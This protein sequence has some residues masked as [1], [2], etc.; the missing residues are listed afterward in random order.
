[1]NVIGIIP[2]RGGS[3]GIL[4]KNIQPL[5]GTPLIVRTIRTLS[6]A[7]GINN[8]YVS[9]DN[10]EIAAIAGKNGAGI[11]HRPTEIAGDTATS[12]SAILNA[13]DVLEEKITPSD[14]IVFAQCT[15]PFTCS[16]EVKEAILMV[17]SAQY[18]S[19]FSAKLNHS[20]L[21]KLTSEGEVI[22]INHNKNNQRQRRQDLESNFLETGAFYVFKVDDFKKT[23]NRFCGRTGVVISKVNPIEIDEESDLVLAEAFAKFNEKTATK[24]T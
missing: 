16:E 18:Q 19:V 12:E 13:I 10:E 3:K 24:I 8:V 5:N 14:I 20:F 15:S 6:K 4:R 22:G 9:T 11:I 21:W 2:A 17:Q 7:I 1:M 23:Q